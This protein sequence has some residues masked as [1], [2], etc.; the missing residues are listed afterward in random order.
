MFITTHTACGCIPSVTSTTTVNPCGD[1]LRVP[2]LILDCVDSVGPCGGVGQI[3]LSTFNNGDTFC[4]GA[5]EYT[6]ISFDDTAFVTSPTINLTTGV[7]DF[8]TTSAAVPNSY[9]VITYQVHCVD[10]IEAAQ[11]SIQICIQDQCQ[12]VVC[13][14]G[15]ACDECDGICKDISDIEVS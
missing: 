6:L 13:P 3:D 15:Q 4:G 12:N 9:P 10:Q 8:I 14:A 2:G 5:V 11:G 7:L 1:C